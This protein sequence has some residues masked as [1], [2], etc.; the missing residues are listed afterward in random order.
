MDRQRQPGDFVAT[1]VQKG[2]VQHL[3]WPSL[4]WHPGFA[5]SGKIGG[6]EQ[7]PDFEHAPPCAWKGLQVGDARIKGSAIEPP[8]LGKLHDSAV[9]VV[10][11]GI[12]CGKVEVIVWLFRTSAVCFSSQTIASW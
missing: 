7:G 8:S 1:I 12:G 2:R 9:Q 3:N 11:E 5:Q 4:F 6:F 10:A